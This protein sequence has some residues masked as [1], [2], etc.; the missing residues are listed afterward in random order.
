MSSKALVA[1]AMATKVSLLLPR[2]Q[3]QGF[4]TDGT[5]TH[6]HVSFS[7]LETHVSGEPRYVQDNMRIHAREVAHWVMEENA[8]VYVCGSVIHVASSNQECTKQGLI[9]RLFHPESQ[10]TN[11][12]SYIW[13]LSPPCTWYFV[14]DR[15]RLTVC[16]TRNEESSSWIHA[17]VVKCLCRFLEVHVHVLSL[18]CV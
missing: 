3:L 5:L 8:V 12:S 14:K 15:E 1:I 4:A 6:L 13:S 10:M 18:S 9:L 11:I 17:R 2:D 16:M 7:R